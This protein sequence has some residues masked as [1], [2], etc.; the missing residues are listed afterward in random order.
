MATA[1]AVGR[2]V[3]L[4]CLGLL[5]YYL[6]LLASLAARDLRE[7]GWGLGRTL[8]PAGHPALSVPSLGVTVEWEGLPAAARRQAIERLADAGVGWVRLRLGWEALEPQPGRFQWAPYDAWLAELHAAGIAPVVLLDGSPAW[9]QEPRDRAAG[10]PL[11]PPA[12]PQSFARFAAAFAGRFGASVRFYQIWDEPN[13]APHW[14]SHHIDP[15]G[16]AQLLRAA[17]PALRAADSD[18]VILTAA[19]APTRDRGHL[20]IDE[21][22][23]LQR[24][25]AAGAAGAF[26]AVAAQPF[27]FGHA[28]TD[29]RQSI[30]RLNF[31][32]VTL[33]RRALVRAGLAETPIWAVRFGWNTRGD[34]P[35]G[36][37]T[38]ADQIAHA[39][40]ARALAARWPWLATLGWA[41]D[42]PAA[43]ESDP[44]WGFALTDALLHG[45]TGAPLPALPGPEPRAQQRA[46]AA[47][48]AGLAVLCAL[49]VAAGWREGRSLPWA[50]AAAWVHAQPAWALG[51]AW[52]GLLIVYYLATWPP[53]IA[54][55]WGA[56]AALALVRPAVGVWLA[57]ALLPFHAQHKEVTLGLWRLTV[58]PAAAA[59]LVLLPAAGR[60]LRLQVGPRWTGWRWTGWRWTDGLALAWLLVNLAAAA[61]VWQWSAYRRGLV[62]LALVPLL[63][64]LAL[65]LLVVADVRTLRHALAALAA[66]GVLVACM[67]LVGWALGRGVPIDGVRRLV[68]PHFSPNH[69]ALYL[70]RTLFVMLG[71]ALGVQGVRRRAGLAV[72]ALVALALLLTA[73]RGALL[74]G[75]PAGLATSLWLWLRRADLPHGPR[76]RALL[77]RPVVRALLVAL[78]LLLLAVLLLGEARLF[79]RASVDSRFLLWQAA[80]G[81]WRALPWTGAGPGGFVWRYPAFLPTEIGVPALLEPELLHPHNLWLEAAANWGLVGLLWLGTLLVLWFGWAARRLNELPGALQWPAIG[82][83]AA[84][85]AAVAHGQVDAFLALPD[86]AAWLF[87]ALALTHCVTATCDAEAPRRKGF[88]KNSHSKTSTRINTDKHGFIGRAAGSALRPQICVY[89]CLSV[90]LSCCCRS[91][92]IL[93]AL[94]PL[95]R[96][97]QC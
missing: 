37:V 93:C 80:L 7:S 45:L 22:Y 10:S 30:E 40:D 24:M 75:V 5:L 20:A 56:A 3:R 47:Q 97:S 21:V 34:S 77:R 87:A 83:V 29:P 76:L 6:L 32:R 81:V 68:G 13:I 26:D 4:L 36:T 42:A 70:L 14:G 92:R 79:N 50:R 96:R 43:L 89:P 39:R 71:L 31:A 11:A 44:R 60:A 84:L 18:A 82:L 15:V 58:P 12:D 55:C 94:A 91:L 69:T 86:L 66:G 59:V 67:G 19:L 95:R 17:A 46:A 62:D 1:R 73:S 16:Y 61:G 74:L 51:A 53:L 23:F 90:Y 64:Y 28:P 48:L 49:L 85:A 52:G 72:T 8:P 63:L 88:A 2:A 35:W 41:V 54:A 9:A 25:L 33:L 27:G 78:P 65:R 38:A 57:L